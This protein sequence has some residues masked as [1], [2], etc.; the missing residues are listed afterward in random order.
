MGSKDRA[1]PR[2]ARVGRVNGHLGMNGA[3]IQPISG[4]EQRIVEL[5]E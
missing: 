3:R 4:S 5:V 2:V 1:H